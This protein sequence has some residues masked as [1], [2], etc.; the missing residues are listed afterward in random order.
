VR[1]NETTERAG[2]TG[3][4][5]VT[6]GYERNNPVRLIKEADMIVCTR[7]GKQGNGRC[8]CEEP[9]GT[10][11]DPVRYENEGRTA[12][13]R[14]ANLKRNIAKFEADAKAG[15]VLCLSDLIGQAEQCHIDAIEKAR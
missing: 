14:R 13:E 11:D 5:P 15:K 7:C 12:A 4:T 3:P 1:A 6:T 2:A 10:Y 8:D 9:A